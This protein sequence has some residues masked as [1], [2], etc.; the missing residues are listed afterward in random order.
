MILLV[1]PLSSDA[2]GSGT[3]ATC[4]AAAFPAAPDFAGA[5][6]L[7]CATSVLTAFFTC[8]TCR[9]SQPITYPA[10]PPPDLPPALPF[11]PAALP[12]EGFPDCGLPGCCL[13]IG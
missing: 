4:G 5:P 6:P 13:A 7:P 8:P 1:D 10:V 11:P 12:D 3:G 2:S 9:P